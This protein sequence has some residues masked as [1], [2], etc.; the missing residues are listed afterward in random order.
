MLLEENPHLGSLSGQL[1]L[2]MHYM[3][4][5][6]FFTGSVLALHG[7]EHLVLSSTTNYSRSQ[8]VPVA[9]H[10][11]IYLFIK[12]LLCKDYLPPINTHQ[13][14]DFE[15]LHCYSMMYQKPSPPAYNMGVFCSLFLKEQRRNIVLLLIP[16]F[17]ILETH[18]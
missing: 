6:S 11:V 10:R 18:Q 9:G 1:G 13:K 16:S 7:I 5:M 14:A 15:Y 17:E 4:T 3:G 8:G 12:T 2:S